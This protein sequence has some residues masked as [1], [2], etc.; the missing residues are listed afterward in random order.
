VLWVIDYK[1]S[2]HEGA[3]VDA[4]LDRE[5]ERY[6]PQLARYAKALGDTRMGLYFPLLSGWREWKGQ[7]TGGEERQNPN[8]RKE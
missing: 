8:V 6:A 3:G 2:R 4:F 1:T 5:L 7:A